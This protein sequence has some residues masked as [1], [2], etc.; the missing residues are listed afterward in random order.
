ML[1]ALRNRVEP[2]LIGMGGRIPL[3]PNSVSSIAFAFSALALVAL[4][5]NMLLAGAIF[6]G[7]NGLFDGLD[8][9][10]AKARGVESKRGDLLDHVLDRYAD[11]FMMLGVS[12]NCNSYLALT[13]LAVVLLI[14]YTGVEAQ[15]LA[16]L[17]NYGG[18]LGR[19][20]RIVLLIVFIISQSLFGPETIGFALLDLLMVYF[21]IVG[22]ITVVQRVLRLWRELAKD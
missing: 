14:S 8:G 16:G 7:L 17:R 22:N 1:D 2:F 10:V 18:L 20:D 13:A 15:A 9:A 6:I 11:L 4:F 5:K 3:S 19:A 21:L 12:F